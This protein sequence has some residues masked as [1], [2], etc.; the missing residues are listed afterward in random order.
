MTKAFARL[1]ADALGGRIGRDQFGM[2][3]FELLQLNHEL[4]EFGVGDFG[5][6][7]DVV[8]VFVVA[9]FFPQCFDLL[10]GALG[11]AGMT[12]RLYSGDASVAR[13][14]SPAAFAFDFN[15]PISTSAFA[16]ESARDTFRP[17][18]VFRG[19][20]PLAGMA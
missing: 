13:A 20:N 15:L 1:A 8:E 12:E 2:F 19:G 11:R 6:V 18:I 9:D 17:S 16:G 10:F 4:V 7:E 3:V 5:I 14:P